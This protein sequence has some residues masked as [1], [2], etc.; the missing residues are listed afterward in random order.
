MSLNKLLQN[1]RV[2]LYKKPSTWILIGIIL[3][4]MLL[5]MGLTKFMYVYQSNGQ[6]SWSYKDNY[7]YNYQEFQATYEKDPTDLNAKYMAEKFDYLLTN[8]IPENDWRAQVVDAYYQQLI[9]IAQAETGER[10]AEGLEQDK[11]A[12]E[13]YKKI[14]DSNDWRELVNLKIEALET[15][16]YD[17]VQPF[18]NGSYPETEQERQ[19]ALEVQ[20]MYLEYNVVPLA[21][22]Y[23]YYY[24][25]SDNDNPDKWKND[26]LSAIQANKLTLL[27]GEDEE[28]GEPLNASSRAKLQEQIDIYIE[29]LRSNSAPVKA[30]S[31]LGFM[32]SSTSSITLITLI[33]MVVAGG[34]IATEFGTGTIKLLLIT[35]HKRREIFWAKTLLLLELILIA[36]G[37]MFVVAF[38]F[39]GIACGF[40]GIGDSM[41]LSLFGQVVRI[42][43]LV[44]ILLKYLLSLLPVLV[45]KG[46]S[47]M[48]SAVT[49]KSA[50]AIAI[51]IMLMF[52]SE[53]IN[54]LLIQM[55]SYL[56]MAIPGIKFLFFVNTDLT[57]YLPSL[58]STG[59]MMTA[60][61]TVDSSMT[62][63]FSVLVLL[64]TLVCF[65]WIARDSFCRR[66]VK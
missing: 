66:D 55:R 46:L 20:K 36:A 57:G 9:A 23:S 26:K 50:V 6:S 4:F 11:A 1:E 33:L 58:V 27:R 10:P 13:T 34:M 59:N 53:M 15:G 17:L 39:S 25:G 65:L 38:L 2:K 51:S 62:L 56:G 30:D 32:D 41:V 61:N 12:A 37:S 43:C 63:G 16:N 19:V 40:S 44:F 28:T 49:R 8:D 48:L 52:G 29:Q 3:A 22:G 21:S 42:P 45:Y 60:V 64:V 5:T 18:M 54:M 47:Y 24:M 7:M 35:P 14:L 31:F